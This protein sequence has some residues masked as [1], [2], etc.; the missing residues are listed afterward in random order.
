MSKE[1]RKNDAGTLVSSISCM[2]NNSKDERIFPVSIP[3]N[4]PLHQNRICKL[5]APIQVNRSR[6]EQIMT[7]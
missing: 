5:S 6:D 3:S 7:D 1:R 2:E 4:P